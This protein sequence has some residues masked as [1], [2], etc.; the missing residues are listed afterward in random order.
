M[1]KKDNTMLNG[2]TSNK[3]KKKKS[4]FTIIAISLMIGL[5]LLLKTCSNDDVST[6]IKDNTT[7]V[8]ENINYDELDNIDT[9]P[10]PFIYSEG[11]PKS[12]I[13]YTDEKIVYVKQ[14]ETV[15]IEREKLVFYDQ[16]IYLNYSSSSQTFEIVQA[17]GGATPYIY[18][19]VESSNYFTIS[20]LTVTVKSA[21]P[22]GDYNYGIQVKDGLSN[23]ITATYRI[24]I[25]NDLAIQNQEF[26][27]GKSYQEQRIDITKA[28]GGSGLF[29]YSF[30]SDSSNLLFDPT[31]PQFIVVAGTDAGDY[32]GTIKV[33]D[34]ETKQ[35]ASA[36]I[37]V[38]ID[39]LLF[40]VTFKNNDGVIIKTQTYKEG[41]TPTCEA[42]E[43]PRNAQYT[44][45]FKGWEPEI[46][47]VTADAIYVAIYDKEV[48]KYTVTWK[49]Y[50]G[51][52]IEEDKNV[53]Y[54]TTPHYDSLTPTRLPDVQHSYV[55]E[56]WSSEIVPITGDVTYVA[57]YKD[58]VLEFEVIW[59]NDDGTELGRE[60]YPYGDIPE[61]KS[62]TPTK[63]S[64]GAF[65]YEF[66]GWSP[67]ISP[68]IDDITYVA[69][70]TNSDVK[71]TVRWL[72][73]DEQTVLKTDTNVLYGTTPD[74]FQVVNVP[75]KASTDQFDYVFAGWSPN[76]VEIGDEDDST[77]V[78]QYVAQYTPVTRKYTV[79][80]K[81]YDGTLLETDPAIEYGTKP[82]YNGATPSKPADPA[83]GNYIFK[84]WTIDES[85]DDTV[86]TSEDIP[87][88]TGNITYVAYFEGSLNSFTV[89][90]MNDL[91]VVLKTDTNVEYGTTPAYTGDTP[92][93]DSTEKYDYEFIG[94][95][96]TPSP[97][98]SD[99]TYVAK[100]K[101]VLRAYTVK[102]NNYDDSLIKEETINYGVTPS[103]TGDTP[104]RDTDAH[105]TYTFKEWT[106]EITSVRGPQVYTATYEETIN[107]YTVTWKM[108]ATDFGPE[109]I[110]ET[111]TNV[112]Y[113]DVPSYN[114]EAVFSDAK[115]VYV[116]TGW[117]DET[118]NSAK[119]TPDNELRPVH[120]DVTYVAKFVNATN[121][122]IVSFDMQ[123]HGATVLAQY[124]DKGELVDEPIGV[125]AT[126]YT[127]GGWYKEASCTNAWD[128]ENDTVG[129][130]NIVL[131]AKW[132]ANKY[133]I[134]YELNEGTF[135]TNHPTTATYDIDFNVSNPTRTG[136]TFTGW[137]ITGMSNDTHIIGGDY[138]TGT[139]IDSTKAEA[140]RNLQSTDNA[141]VIF[142]AQW[143]INKY[144]ITWKN[145]DGTTLKTEQFD[146]GTTPTYTGSTPT[147]P[148]T[149]Q[150]SYVFAG[151]DPEPVPATEPTTYTAIFNEVINQYTITVNAG[152]GGSAS[153]GGTV[154]YG[155][156]VTITATP[157]SGYLF[158]Q[159]NDGDKNASRTITVYDN[160]TYT[161][162]FKKL[163]AVGDIIILNDNNKYRVLDINN[164]TKVAF[165]IAMFDL[166]DSSGNII[167]L[168]GSGTMS[169][170]NNVHYLKYGGY[171]PL[172]SWLADLNNDIDNAIIPRSNLQQDVYDYS[173]GSYI[174]G[175]VDVGEH[176]VFLISIREVKE[177]F[178]RLG[179]SNPSLS[180]VAGMFNADTS[181]HTSFLVRDGYDW[182][183]VGVM[184]SGY[185]Y[186]H[187]IIVLYN[188]SG[189][190]WFSY[191]DYRITSNLRPAFDINLAA[192][193]L[194]Y[195]IQ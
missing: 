138:K 60:S 146:Y 12:T 5:L 149:Q 109:T 46:V 36:S 40:Q 127:F 85:N 191:A 86:Y 64:T 34:L 180:D 190:T 35:T 194:S 116:I 93:R 79:K 135:G 134:T 20:G 48:N 156:S 31:I 2:E 121:K 139:S 195:T 117:Y 92:A 84:G 91:G 75:T 26:T 155:S 126:G 115:G 169:T 53:P 33:K 100:F 172:T 142:T 140:F 168:P 58:T 73:D 61:Y 182:T 174:Y 76:V 141:T 4:I 78:I 83:S 103:Y 71:Y 43:L 32:T 145:H 114:G 80:W 107:K 15:P 181:S 39:P 96:P 99:I 130:T 162:S 163:P 186:Q 22:V 14:T 132:T 3:K 56:K 122:H 66:A 123:G 125:S 97:I 98:I 192:D 159:W 1:E 147:K 29:E 65:T 176:K 87:N 101:E 144:D 183:N 164:D 25:V 82:T 150:Y 89:T 70:Y 72:D 45:T 21:T 153:G 11:S 185:V 151:W 131:Y 187:A 23:A 193:G 10:S 171:A 148:S 59:E 118:D 6:P 7:T 41:E 119:E 170:I 74:Y 189:R 133:N 55:F 120:G 111:D 88:V 49:N 152:T 68:V 24:H 160:A 137:N 136:Y 51:T 16:D 44:Y 124:K 108:L 158:T 188:T 17:T 9:Y 128:F 50:D 30:T 129:D 104:T 173:S 143:Q 8:G 167:K 112:P 175:T 81:N 90:W 38:T 165:V 178:A 67:T 105:Y 154:N 27:I 177:Y 95:S 13:Y 113:G 63:N 28:T 69:T 179:N 57:L 77:Q 62:E 52:I 54:G 19:E 42:P 184:G 18:S 102:W 94:W 166:K 37:T 110:L 106:P 157:N 47:P 161:A